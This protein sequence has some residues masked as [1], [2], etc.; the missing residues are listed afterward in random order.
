MR[1]EAVT[2]TA[3][4]Q[5]VRDYAKAHPEKSLKEIGEV[6]RISKQR[7]CVLLGKYK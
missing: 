2:K 4:N 7:V 1:Y 6:F 3:R 5:A